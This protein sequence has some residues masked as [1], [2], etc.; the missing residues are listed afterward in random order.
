MF[1][2]PGATEHTSNEHYRK[3]GYD[4]GRGPPFMAPNHRWVWE[5]DDL[6]A[7]RKV[8]AEISAGW[9]GSMPAHLAPN[10]GP[11]CAA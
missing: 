2:M 7:L 11:D 1:V 9:N 6:P 10:A 4:I 3:L 5:H 8:F